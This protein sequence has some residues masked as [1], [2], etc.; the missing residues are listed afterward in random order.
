MGKLQID[1]LGASFAVQAH[2]DDAYLKKLLN[3]YTEI[4][5]TIK[6]AGHLKDPVQISIMAGISIAAAIAFRIFFVFIVIS[7]VFNLSKEARWSP[8]STFRPLSH[9]STRFPPAID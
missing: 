5:N 4:T 3:Y 2:E 9:S 7:S 6:Q 1:M 8:P